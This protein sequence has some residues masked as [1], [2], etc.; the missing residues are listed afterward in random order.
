MVI[1]PA[2]AEDNYIDAIYEYGD[3]LP[4]EEFDEWDDTDEDRSFIFLFAKLIDFHHNNS[5]S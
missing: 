2:G 3:N 1:V 5:Y 4:E